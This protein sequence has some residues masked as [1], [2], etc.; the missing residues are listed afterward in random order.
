VS[1]GEEA[2]MEDQTATAR[3]WRSPRIIAAAACFLLGAAVLALHFVPLP[4]TA[5][6]E[7]ALSEPDRFETELDASLSELPETEPPDDQSD[8]LVVYVTGAVVAPDV[9]R[10]AARA[11]V[12]DAVVAA[13]GLRSDAAAEQV[14]L[15]EPVEDAQHVH[16]PALDEAAAAQPAA[17]EEDGRLDLNR[18]SAADLEE[19]PGIGKVLAQRILARRDE[20]G[21]FETVEDLRAVSGV[22]AK[23]FEQIAPLVSVGD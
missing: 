11:R 20:H 23:L 5:T 12:K 18:A 1:H 21:P 16:V 8:E 7:P 4:A 10:L 3:S 17:N 2:S 14:N 19:L 15:A 22:G 6:A 9:Y 13:G